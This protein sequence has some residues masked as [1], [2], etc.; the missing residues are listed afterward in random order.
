MLKRGHMLSAV[1]RLLG[2]EPPTFRTRVQEFWAWFAKNAAR[3]YDAIEAKR[4]DDLQPEVSAQMDRLQE[5]AAWVFGPGQDG[6]GHSLTFTAEG[7]RKRQLLTAYWLSQAPA[8]QG[9]TFY[10]T[11]QRDLQIDGYQIHFANQVFDPKEFWLVPH[12][13]EQAE[14]IELL[15]WH[16]A[17]PKLEERARWTAIF[18][19]LDEV[20]GELCTQSFIGEITIGDSRL[21]EAIP[22]KEL[23]SFVD[24]TVEKH[25]W[26]IDAPGELW[27]SY[28]TKEPTRGVL[29][30]DIIAGST[31]VFALIREV[32]EGRLEPDPLEGTGAEYVYVAFSRSELPSGN[33]VEARGVIEEALTEALQP[34]GSG[35]VI[36]GAIGLDYAYIDLL[37]FDGKTSRGIVKKVLQE[38]GL[39]R[40]TSIEQF[41]RARA[42]ERIAL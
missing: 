36:G 4:S 26:T 11:K 18:L 20:L 7:D 2:N 22:L 15:V 9:W 30:G 17:F 23:P 42:A 39:G 16:P 37:L 35:M 40:G 21:A 25:G 33:E 10:A 38:K 24:A 13:D 3:I 14:Q 8:L 19:Y 5:G 28:Q 6:V 31:A 12:V 1:K 34:S 41:A 32:K 27:S 29:R